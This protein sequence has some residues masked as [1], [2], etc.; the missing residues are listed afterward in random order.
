MIEKEFTIKIKVDE[1]NI[2]KLYNNYDINYDSVE[3]FIIMLIRNME[4]DMNYNDSM[5]VFG[6]EI[7]CTNDYTRGFCNKTKNNKK[8]LIGKNNPWIKI[9]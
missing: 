7:Y 9:K 6:Y 8:G 5:K 3:D 2:S 4:T 1:K